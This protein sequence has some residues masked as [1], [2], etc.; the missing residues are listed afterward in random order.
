VNDNLDA[1]LVIGCI[2]SILQSLIVLFWQNEAKII[3][4][5]NGA[6]AGAV[7]RLEYGGRRHSSGSGIE[8]TR[9]IKVSRSAENTVSTVS[10]VRTARSNGENKHKSR[11]RC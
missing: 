9:M 6:R 8:G 10:I 1:F 5:F 3:N 7:R 11:R 2:L 4:V